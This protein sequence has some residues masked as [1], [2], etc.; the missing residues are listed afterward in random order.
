MTDPPV[1]SAGLSPA[2]GGGDNSAPLTDNPLAW[3]LVAQT[4]AHLAETSA[5]DLTPDR[6]REALTEVAVE[7]PVAD[8]EACEEAERLLFL[9]YL[10][11]LPEI[12]KV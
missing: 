7:L 11:A 1:R 6:I 10:Q 5:E 12:R 8:P 9:S 3:D 4:M 2:G